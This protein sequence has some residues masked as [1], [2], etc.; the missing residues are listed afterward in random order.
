MIKATRVQ[1]AVMVALSA[2]T[3]LL[4]AGQTAYCDQFGGVGFYTF[5]IVKL[6]VFSCAEVAIVLIEALVFNLAL[7]MDGGSAFL[8]SLV[9]NV[10]S[11]AIGV[12]IIPSK[13]AAE[14]P[15]GLLVVLVVELPIIVLLNRDYINRGRLLKVGAIT[16]VITYLSAAGLILALRAW[17]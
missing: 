16:N 1:Q 8:T 7:Q 6:L 17:Q 9:A 3:M 14:I 13:T 11:A 10:A 12:M 2:A 15:V 4:V 5:G